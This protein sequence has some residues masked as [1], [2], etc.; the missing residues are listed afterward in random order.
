MKS[1]CGV[2][3]YCILNNYV[4]LYFWSLC[5]DNI[6][7]CVAHCLIARRADIA[8]LLCTQRQDF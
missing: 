3:G 8:M 7:C 4:T 1:Y 6:I 5:I 2:I